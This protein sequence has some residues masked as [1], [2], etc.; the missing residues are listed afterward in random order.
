MTE[1]PT[2]FPSQHYEPE[3]YRALTRSYYKFKIKGHGDTV[4]G[5][6][7]EKVANEFRGQRG[8]T[9]NQRSGNLTLSK[10]IDANGRS[11][12][13]DRAMQSIVD[14]G[15]VSGL[16]GLCGDYLPVIGM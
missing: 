7:P 1:L 8:W 11:N 16:D 3:A 4:F 12:V 14:R 15:S 2:R 6:V 10:G 9:V 13:F 5:L